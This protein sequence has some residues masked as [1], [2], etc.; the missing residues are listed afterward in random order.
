[1]AIQNFTQREIFILQQ[2]AQNLVTNPTFAATRANMTKAEMKA[3]DAA[4]I[5]AQIA[6]IQSAIDNIDATY[7]T[8]KANQLTSLNDSLDF[9]NGLL[10]KIQNLPE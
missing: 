8:L 5:S 3:A 4:A 1:M 9:Y 6:A 7:A 2:A 10:T